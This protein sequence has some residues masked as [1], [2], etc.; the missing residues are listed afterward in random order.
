MKKLTTVFI[1]LLFARYG[2]AGHIAGGEMYY[3]YIG[4]GT[5]PNSS[6]YQVT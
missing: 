4:P 5:S 6:Q 1:L 3:K 2:F